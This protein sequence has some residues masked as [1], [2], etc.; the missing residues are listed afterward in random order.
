[1]LL[2]VAALA[3]AGWFGP[4]SHGRAVSYEIVD[5]PLYLDY[6]QGI[7]DGSWPYRDVEVEYPPLA[8]APM[9]AARPFGSEERSYTHA[10]RREM[11]LLAALL[12]V[13]AACLALAQGLGRTSAAAAGT[14]AALAPVAVG[15]V[16]ATRFDLWPT[17]LVALALV[18]LAA[19]RVRVGAV[20]LALGAAAK[21]WP[22]VLLPL[23]LAGALRRGGRR[24]AA[25]ALG[26]FLVVLA[27]VFGPVAILAPDGLLHS[28]RVQAGRPLQIESI[29]ATAL[30][31]VD[32]VHDLGSYGVV[33]GS[34]SQNLV[35]PGVDAVTSLLG[36]LQPL[37]VLLGVAVG[38]RL[39]LRTRHPAEALGPA[40]AAVLLGTV[41][42]GRVLSPQFMVWLIPVVAALAVARAPLERLAAGVLVGALVLTNIEFPHRYWSLGRDL[43]P[44]TAAVVLARDGLLVAA[45]ALAVAACLRPLEATAR[46]AALRR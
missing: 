15:S 11:G 7:V 40:A 31:A 42:F 25:A 41:A 45:Y 10:Y 28:L 30:V 17:L 5:T 18:A 22:V 46:R 13:A 20:L 9:L 2:G 26:W 37:A 32:A 33:T 1:M 6:A 29:G 38:T 36:V 16:V 35:G 24:E 34:G 4:L 3:L 8:F 21:L 23:L 19:G 12:A 27:L 14:V 39:L 43:D 44:G